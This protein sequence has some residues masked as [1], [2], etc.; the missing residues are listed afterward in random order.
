L[1]FAFASG[2]GDVKDFSQNHP[3]AKWV[4]KPYTIDSLQAL[5]SRA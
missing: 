5:F 1:P 2:Y 4:Q 3:N